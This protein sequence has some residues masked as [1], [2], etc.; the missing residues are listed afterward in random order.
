MKCLF[1][2]WVCNDDDDDDDDVDNV[3]VVQIKLEA[4]RVEI[5]IAGMS[6]CFFNG[7]LSI[8]EILD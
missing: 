8:F 4:I 2:T 3:V 7:Q 5:F 1:R 6:I